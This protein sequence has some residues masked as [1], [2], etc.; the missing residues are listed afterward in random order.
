MMQNHLFIWV[1]TFC[2]SCGGWF[3]CQASLILASL[4]CRLVVILYRI[5]TR[6]LHILETKIPTSNFNFM[7]CWYLIRAQFVAHALLDYIE[8]GAVMV[9]KLIAPLRKVPWW[10]TSWSLHLATWTIVVSF[11][12][13]LLNG[14][15]SCHPPWDDAHYI[16]THLVPSILDLCLIKP[17]APDSWSGKKSE[18]WDWQQWRR[19]H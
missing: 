8:E 18:L 16:C 9:H 17:T 6:L 19:N 5:D 4:N 15:R 10:Y 3:G 11:W 1:V 2:F 13:Q 7:W 14:W 12:L